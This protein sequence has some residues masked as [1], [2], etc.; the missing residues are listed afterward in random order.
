MQSTRVSHRQ[1]TDENA[2]A[3]IAYP[4]HAAYVDTGTKESTV[5][6]P[7]LRQVQ[8]DEV[9]LTRSL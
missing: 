2:V 9:K 4:I 7:E 5:G 1:D 6:R 8:T 3:Y